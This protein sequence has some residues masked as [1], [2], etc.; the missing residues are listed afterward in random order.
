MEV[1][2]YTLIIIGLFFIV[3]GI[4][5][6]YRFHNFYA[7]LLSAADVDTV[8]LITILA[9]AAFLSGFTPFTLKLLLILGLLVI[10]NPIVTSSI[11]SSA[12][13][14]GYKLMQEEDDETNE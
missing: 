9:G 13:F 4:V 6:I 11:A 3:V 8:G 5:G 2:G 1:I 12:F 7:R 10:L 14:S